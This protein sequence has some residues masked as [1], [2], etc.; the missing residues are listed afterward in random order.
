[1]SYVDDVFY[2]QTFVDTLGTGFSLITRGEVGFGRPCVGISIHEGYVDFNPIDGDTFERIEELYHE[3]L[4]PKIEDAY[5]K[6]DCFAVLVHD[7]DYEEGLRQLREWVEDIRQHGKPVVVEYEGSRHSL[8]AFMTGDRRSYA[9]TLQEY[10][11]D[12][13][14]PEPKSNTGRR[15]IL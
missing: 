12:C 4:F 5:H 13:E 15:V 8:S 7:D 6:H 10:E 11:D 3:E 2:L 9:M 1:M 14:R